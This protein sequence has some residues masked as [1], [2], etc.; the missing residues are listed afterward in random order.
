VD[1]I[2][3]ITLLVYS[4]GVYAYG[5]LLLGMLRAR[6]RAECLPGFSRPG[7][8][9]AAEVTGTV[10]LVVSFL[11]FVVSVLE[12]VVRLIP[13]WFTWA[14]DFARMVIVYTFPPLIMQM[15]YLEA[16]QRSGKLGHPF[17][18]RAVVAMWVL[19]PAVTAFCFVGFLG[20]TGLSGRFLGIFSGLSIGV[21]FGLTAVYSLLASNRG[22]PAEES[23]D[24]HASRRSSTLLY[25]FVIAIVLTGIVA[26]GYSRYVIE[27]V[28]NVGG[29]LPLAFLFVGFYHEDRFRFFDIFIKRALAMAFSVAL[30]A[31]FFGVLWPRIAGLEIDAATRPWVYAMLL[32][33]FAL[34]LPWLGSLLGGWLDRWWFG[35]RF[36]TVEAVKHFLAGLQSA[37]NERELVERA[38]RGLGEIFRAPSRIDLGLRRAPSLDFDCVLNMPIRVD[39]RD[40]GAIL[41]GRRARHIPYFSGD[42]ALVGSLGDVFS[43]ML[44]NVR[45]QERKQEQEQREQELSLQASRSELKALR[46][47]INP[48]FLFNALNTIAGLIHKDPLHADR[49]VEQLAD[50][51]RYTLRGSETEWARLEDELDFVRA[52]L[53]VER[54]RFGE[55]L[56]VVIETEEEVGGA[57]VP[58]MLVQTLVEN[59]VKHGVTR[60][61]GTARVEVRAGSK[62]G[63]LEVEVVDN[64]PGFDEGGA[65][66]GRSMAGEGFG[67]RSVRQRLR[68]HFGDD[69]AVAIERRDGLTRVRVELPLLRATGVA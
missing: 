28:R 69:A 13:E 41:M 9:R 2:R 52:Y 43:Y 62:D 1:K 38:E 32:L 40:V 46:A 50:V 15:V 39:G 47:Q 59:A 58:T 64:G 12:V 30:L 57:R 27:I 48:H 10:L 44:E 51:F 68:G 66:A 49:T 4:F 37:T 33:P 36:S 54:A 26:G 55:R 45:L 17:W 11:W 5:S 3:L 23:R 65:G 8:P 7:R 14:F 25:A 19:A 21:M 67:L 6:A 34:A 24:E 16:H 22:R 20:L 18:R 60:T 35:R 53:D 56:R 63:R 31:G 29:A 61:R 42:A